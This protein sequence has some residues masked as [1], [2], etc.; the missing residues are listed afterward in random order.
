MVHPKP[1]TPAREALYGTC[2]AATHDAAALPELVQQFEAFKAGDADG[3]ADVPFQMLTALAAD[4]RRLGADRPRTR[5][6]R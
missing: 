1:A 4:R 5:R 2:S 6:G 3:G